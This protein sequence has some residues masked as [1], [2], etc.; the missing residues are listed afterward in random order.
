MNR[1]PMKIF[2]SLLQRLMLLFTVLF[3][4]GQSM[5]QKPSGEKKLSPRLLQEIREGKIKGKTSFRITVVGAGI[6][7]EINKPSFNPERIFGDGRFS[8]YTITGTVNDIMQDLLLS[9][10][11]I[12]IESGLRIPKEELLLERLDISANK[13]NMVHSLYP[14]WNGEGRVVSVKENKPDTLDIDFAGRFL[15]TNLSSAIVNAHATIMATMIAGAGNSWH[16]GK[17]AAWGSTISSADFINLLPDPDAAYRQ[18]NITV[19]NHSYGVGVE[20]YYGSDALLYDMSALD[21]KNLIHV[22]SSGNA[23]SSAAAT[24]AYSGLPGFANLTGSFKMAKNVLTVGATDSFGVV[25]S[26]SSKGP[27]HDGRVKPELVAFG[28][29]GSSGAA[30]LVSGTALILQDAY[31]DLNDSLPSN[32]LVKAVL[33]NS[34]DDVGNRE[35]DYSNG[36][37]SLNARNAVHTIH[38]GRHFSGTVA[39]RGVKEFAVTIP[40]GIK[41]VKVTLVWN[42]PPALPNAEKALTNDLDL[43]LENDLSGRNWMPWVLNNYP[44]ADSL[45]KPAERKRDSLNNVEQITLDNPVAGNYH[46]RVI[47]FDVLGMQDFFLAYQFDSTDIFEWQFPTNLDFIT[48]ASGNNIRWHSSLNSSAGV[49]EY[50]TDK[51]S[52]WQKIHDNVDLSAGYFQ[53]K[54]PAVIEQALLRMSVGTSRF[55]SDTF[56]ISART[57]T[58]VG[59]NCPDS[60]LFYWQKLPGIKDYKIY[61]LGSRYLDNITVTADSLIVLNKTAYPAL[62]FAVAPLIGGKEGMRSFTFD[63]TQQGVECYIR[64]FL[65]ILDNNT[66]KL[67]LSLGTLYGI[68]TIVL[69]KFSAGRYMPYETINQPGSLQIIFSDT[70]LANGLNIYRAKLELAGGKKIYSAPETVY[71]FSGNSF[72]IFPNPIA[73][74]QPLEILTNSNIISDITLMVYDSYGRKI[75]K[76][77]LNNFQEK[78]PT[79][80]LPKGL[81]FFRFIVD[82]E[83]DTIKRVVV[84]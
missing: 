64:S 26:L 59:F 82:G 61:T 41:K 67:T 38:A 70:K 2:A 65:G 34:A 13:I 31:V 75:I 73:Q 48:S 52:S 36:F 11:I 9:G 27:A 72:I 50:S 33:L 55:I 46:F 19:Q 30:A 80:K 32:A 5:A 78:L 83:K 81:Y 4:T 17:G 57:L 22:F 37:G 8:V 68:T 21:N 53:W 3:C 84:Q 49:L 43:I 69:E 28:E 40:P 45:L 76:K 23:G 79:D 58:E 54:A 1:K 16:L 47:G 35:V 60:L 29:D 62:H 7:N 71:S 24:G 25:E 42:D 20:S 44:F 39:N 6:P 74:G 66:A 77:T 56:T 18:Y 10:Q 14:T 12:F 51:G 63:Y 15:P